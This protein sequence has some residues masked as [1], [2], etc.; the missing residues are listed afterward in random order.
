MLELTDAYIKCSTILRMS[1]EMFLRIFFSL[2][3]PLT[4]AWSG[5]GCRDEPVAVRWEERKAAIFLK[6]L[7]VTDVFLS[8]LSH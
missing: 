6:V 4:K 8:A 3:K 5:E 7:S 2:V 1:F